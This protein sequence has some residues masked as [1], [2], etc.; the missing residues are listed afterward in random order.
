MPTWFRSI[1]NWNDGTPARADGCWRRGDNHF[2]RSFR[3]TP[4]T[5]RWSSHG[6]R[7]GGL[8]S[9]QTEWSCS[10]WVAAPSPLAAAPSRPAVMRLLRRRANN[11]SA[12]SVVMI[13]GKLRQAQL[14]AP[15]SSSVVESDL[16]YIATANHECARTRSPWRGACR[17]RICSAAAL[18]SRRVGSRRVV[19]DSFDDVW[20]SPSS[21]CRGESARHPRPYP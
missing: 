16:I 10:V 17:P 8:A 13:R 20:N 3:R 14:V 11:R 9:A 1:L 15:V 18:A 19:E 4:Q 21:R 7:R 2:S 5:V 6:L 12:R